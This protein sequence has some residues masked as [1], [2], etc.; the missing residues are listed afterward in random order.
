MSNE[1]KQIKHIDIVTGYSLWSEEYDTFQNPMIFMAD[2]ALSQH[3]LDVQKK[4]VLELGCGTGRNLSTF[5]HQGF[6]SFTGLDGSTG[7][8]EKAQKKSDDKNVTWI[9]A[10]LCQPLPFSDNQFDVVLVSLVLEH[11]FDLQGIFSEVHRVLKNYGTFRI[12]EIHESMTSK[13]I[14]AHF[15]QGVTQ[16]ELPSFSHTE[17][18]FIEILKKFHFTISSVTSWYPNQMMTEKIP[19]IKKH[20]GSAMIIDVCALKQVQL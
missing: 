8:L 15:I 4:V 7:M 2:W 18:E 10:D 9:H 19:K 13:G 20:I 14:K 17:S 1:K 3:V 6:S 16:Y 5:S 12:L 11:I